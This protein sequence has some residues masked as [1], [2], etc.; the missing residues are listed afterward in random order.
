[1]PR[2]RRHAPGPGT[3]QGRWIG[4]AI[5]LVLAA[6]P[7]PSEAVV[8]YTADVHD[9][10]NLLQMLHQLST[11]PQCK[12]ALA[13]HAELR[14]VFAGSALGSA[15]EA[16][17]LMLRH[18]SDQSYQDLSAPAWAELL[19]TA[20]AKSDG[21]QQR[22]LASMRDAA[23]GS[24]GRAAGWPLDAQ[25]ET[26][27][28]PTTMPKII[29]T[30]C[31][32]SRD[33]RLDSSGAIIQ[34]TEQ[35]YTLCMDVKSKSY[36]ITCQAGAPCPAGPNTAKV[37][38]TGTGTSYNLDWSGT[39]T[40][41]P[42]QGCDPPAAKPFSFLLLDDDSRGVATHA[43]SST[44]D[45][46]VE[47]DHYAHARGPGMIMNWYTRNVSAGTDQPKQ[48]VRNSFNYSV[49]GQSAGVGIR[50]FSMNWATP[51]PHSSFAIP[52]ECSSVMDSSAQTAIKWVQRTAALSTLS[53]SIV[54]SLIA[55]GPAVELPG[56]GTATAVGDSDSGGSNSTHTDHDLHSSDGLEFKLREILQQVVEDHGIRSSGSDGG[57]G[58]RYYAGGS[59]YSLQEADSQQV[60]STDGPRKH[61]RDVSGDRQFRWRSAV[62]TFK[63]NAV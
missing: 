11:R 38:Y 53:A 50:D 8:A 31:S 43:G 6:S 63:Y 12:R 13:A 52:S 42:C 22:S 51:A 18:R 33:F 55:P 2:P 57:G 44:L 46:G 61:R 37:V 29:D 41:K 60:Q 35:N 59:R 47:V 21:V 30:F 3:G 49:P 62:G 15:G 54:T 34:G 40:T 23:S 45:D 56:V 5:A 25:E 17:K 16:D 7:A 39:C 1:M 19:A 48:L 32:F 10:G 58:G 28:V 24:L 26:Q 4:A 20:R 9:T 27:I 36:S 14:Q